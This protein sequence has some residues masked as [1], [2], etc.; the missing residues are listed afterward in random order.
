MCVQVNGSAPTR[1]Y[2]STTLFRHELWIFGG[3]YP[4]EDPTPDACSNDIHVFS[5]LEESWY[6]PVVMGNKPQPRSGYE[7]YTDYYLSV[8]GIIM[9]CV[10]RIILCTVDVLVNVFGQFECLLTAC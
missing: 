5:P 9:L 4:V 8:I 7:T 10:A 3:V 2:H 1:S 6:M